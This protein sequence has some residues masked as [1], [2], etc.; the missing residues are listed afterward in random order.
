M[1]RLVCFTRLLPGEP[2]FFLLPMHL[3]PLIHHHLF[4]RRFY[5]TLFKSGKVLFPGLV[6]LG[7]VEYNGQGGRLYV[8]Q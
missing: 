3:R 6:L 7:G 8:G 1:L 2:E 4:P 5:V